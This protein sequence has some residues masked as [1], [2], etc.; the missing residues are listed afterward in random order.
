VTVGGLHDHE[1]GASALKTDDPVHPV[2]FD[3][4][5]VLYLEAKLSEEFG[6]RLEVVDHDAHVFDAQRRHAPD[7]KHGTPASLATKLSV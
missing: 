7:C 4:P 1:I 2:A 3:A 6:G 5:L